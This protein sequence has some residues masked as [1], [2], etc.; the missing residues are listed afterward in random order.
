MRTLA[1]GLILLTSL[2]ATGLAEQAAQR[3]PGQS[4]AA[5]PSARGR[6]GMPPRPA[7]PETMTARQVE[8]YFDQ[9]VLFQARTRLNLDDAQFLRFGAALRQLQDAR[10]TQQRR[11][12]E[13]LRQLD[14]LLAAP[15]PDDNAVSAR[16]KEIDDFGAESNKRIQD[17]YAAIDGVLDV[18]QRA[19]FRV[20][21]ENMERRKL[22]LLARAR[23][24]AGTSGQ[25]APV[26]GAE[27]R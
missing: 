14:T 16:L 20:F 13:I 15:N 10:R 9:V 26:Q 27:A 4:R 21:E 23:Q 2:P 8:Q 6:A 11:R 5:R 3:V 19:R 7:N 18:R 1:L 25:A 17:A 12:A 22:D 24:Q